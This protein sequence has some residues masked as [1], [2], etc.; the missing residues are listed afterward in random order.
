[1]RARAATGVAVALFVALGRVSASVELSS[2]PTTLE[3]GQGVVI[4]VQNDRPA[5]H[6]DAILASCDRTSI[7][8]RVPKRDAGMSHHSGKKHCVLLCNF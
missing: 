2:S 1:M 4:F 7:V 3:D 6:L 8:Q 5:S